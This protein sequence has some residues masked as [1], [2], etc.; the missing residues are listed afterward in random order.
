MTS[1][2]TFCRAS[3]GAHARLAARRL[4]RRLPGVAHRHHARR[5]GRLLRR[6]DGHAHHARHRHPA[7][8]PRNPAR[9]RAGGRARSESEQRHP[10]AGDDRL[11]RLRAP[12]A[13]PGAESARDG[14]R[15]G[16]ESA[17]RALAARDRAAR[18][19]ERDESGDRD[20]DPRPGRRDPVRSR[21]VVS[22]TGSAAAD[23][24]VGTRC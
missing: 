9:H 7:G 10:G 17:R 21:A 24:V 1:A 3:S 14:V 15:H 20:G 12:R 16:R 22:R 18:A 8:L 11:G 19:A 4:Q 13:R 23:A 2:A 5:D 6:L